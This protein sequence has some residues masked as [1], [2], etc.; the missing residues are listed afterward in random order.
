M[1]KHI[2]TILGSLLLA[3]LL[4]FGF[5]RYVYYALSQPSQYR[6]TLRAYVN[7][8]KLCDAMPSC[9]DVTANSGALLLKS[10]LVAKPNLKKIAIDSQLQRTTYSNDEF[11]KVLRDLALSGISV[12]SAGAENE[13][14]IHSDSENPDTSWT[15]L[16]SSAELLADT[17]GTF[18]AAPPRNSK[19]AAAHT[20]FYAKLEQWLNNELQEIDDKASREAI[21]QASSRMLAKFPRPDRDIVGF[22]ALEPQRPSLHPKSQ[23]QLIKSI[24]PS[25]ASARSSYGSP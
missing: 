10:Y 25:S 23:H 6:S 14:F 15:V 2:I 7:I 12:E 19:F 16:A 21:Q 24:L 22:R 20:Q 3:A 8:D 13:F 4:L 5:Y 17:L 11:A 1:N 18:A 9:N